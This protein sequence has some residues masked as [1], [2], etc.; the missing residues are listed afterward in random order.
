VLA[1]CQADAV[2]VGCHVDF[3]GGCQVL[4]GFTLGE[5]AELVDETGRKPVV[6]KLLKLLAFEAFQ[7]LALLAVEGVI[8][9]GFRAMKPSLVVAAKVDCRG[10]AT[11][12]R[13]ANMAQVKRCIIFT[14]SF[15]LLT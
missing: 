14:K 13:K 2:V 8:F 9:R 4:S 6:P 10:A 11:N 15:F 1:G 5:V 12:N 3:A 7:P